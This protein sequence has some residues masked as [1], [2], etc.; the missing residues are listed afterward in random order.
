MSHSAEFFGIA[1]DTGSA[2]AALERAL[3]ADS[4]SGIRVRLG[5]DADGVFRVELN[6]LPEVMSPDQAQPIRLTT[7]RVVSSD[8]YLKHKTSHRAVYDQAVADVPN[9][10]EP[11]LVNERDEITESN[12]ANVVY[13]IGAEWFT[14][15]TTSG[16]LPGTLREELLELGKLIPRVFYVEEL[17]SVQEIALINGLRGWRQTR[18]V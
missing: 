15:P 5:L 4:E 6:E 1:M 10:V 9:G 17:D 7:H 13:R 14:P 12:I 2:R 16:L 18:W 11:I 8:L 3:P